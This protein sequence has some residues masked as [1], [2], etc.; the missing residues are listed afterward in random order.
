M[1]SRRSTYGS[2]KSADLQFFRVTEFLSYLVDFEVRW[3][4]RQPPS[5]QILPLP[6]LGIKERGAARTRVFA[7]A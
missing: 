3:S 7:S 5:S 4:F 2:K 6:S 1:F